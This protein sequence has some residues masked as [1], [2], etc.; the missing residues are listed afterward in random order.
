MLRSIATAV[1]TPPSIST[2]LANATTV[3]TDIVANCIGE[4]LWLA[5]ELMPCVPLL[6]VMAPEE[7][8]TERSFSASA[9]ACSFGLMIFSFNMVLL[10]H[11]QNGFP[12]ILKLGTAAQGLVLTTAVVLGCVVLYHAIA[13][14]RRS[15]LLTAML[16]PANLLAAQKTLQ[17]DEPVF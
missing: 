17:T 10:N 1:A 7:P 5:L 16:A 11:L 8:H 14:V 6:F 4:T 15:V 12:V 3:F 9:W 13:F 2:L